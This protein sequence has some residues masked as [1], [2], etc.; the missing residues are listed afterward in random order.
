VLTTAAPFRQR[1]VSRRG[2]YIEKPGTVKS[3]N[4]KRA[5]GFIVRDDGGKD[6]YFHAST[7]ERAGLRSLSKGQRVIVDVAEWRQGPRSRTVRVV[8]LLS[9]ST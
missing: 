8:P 9:L 1:R 4:A 7:L 5:Y 2:P 6:V 3:F